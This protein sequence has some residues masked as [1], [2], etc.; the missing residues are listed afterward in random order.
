MFNSYNKL[1]DNIKENILTREEF[2]IELEIDLNKNKS[3]ILNYEKYINLLKY[4]NALF[5]K[6]KYIINRTTVL[7]VNYTQMVNNIKNSYRISLPNSEI[8]KYM[9]QI[10]N[11]SNNIIYEIL[12]K[13]LETNKSLKII[14]KT[15]HIKDDEINIKDIYDIDDLNTRIRVS[16]EKDID[17]KEINKL[18]ELFENNRK[19]DD[20]VEMNIIYRLKQRVSLI[21]LTTDNYD[22]SIDLTNVKFNKNMRNFNTYST[23]ELELEALIKNKINKKDLNNILNI[24]T[25]DSEKLIKIIQCSN[26]IIT[27]SD[28]LLVYKNYN[29]LLNHKDTPLT[30]DS[31][32]VISLEIQYLDLLVNKYTVTDKADGDHSFIFIT[33]NKVYIITQNMHIRFTGIEVDE[34]FN[35]T[36]LDGELIFV[37]KY[38]KHIFMGFD[39]LFY[40]GEDVRKKSLLKDRLKCIEMIVQKCF[41]LPKHK[42]KK[43]NNYPD[44]ISLDSNIKFY[45]NEL[46]NYFDIL[47]NDIQVPSNYPLIRPKYFIPL[48]G[49]HDSEIFIYSTI[50]WKYYINS[51]NYPYNLDG[52]VYQPIQHVYET[53]KKNIKMNDYKWKPEENNSI[54]FYIEFAKDDNNKIYTAYDNVLN[55][56]KEEDIGKGISDSTYDDNIIYKICYLYVGKK[57]DNK[58]TFVKFNPQYNNPNH[59]IH[60]TY[61]PID[62]K[63]NVKDIENNIIQDKTVVEFYYDTNITTL[64]KFRWKPI[65]TRHDKTE[66]V[67]KYSK[68]YGNN[69]QVSYKIWNSIKYPVLFNDIEILSDT[70]KYITHREKMMNLVNIDLFEKS[71]SDLYYD[72]DKLIDNNTKPQTDFHNAIKTI[73]INN[74][75]APV[76][77]KKK[78]VF[79]VGCGQ[80]GDIYKF[81]D[82]HVEYAIGLDPV[83]NNLHSA[84]G[85][86][87]RYDRM[88][89]TKPKTP[90]MEFINGDF[91][92]P[93]NTAQQLKTITDR[94]EKNIKLMDKYFNRKYN[95]LNIQF[96]FH[97]FLQN[98]ETWDNACN[99]INKLI[100]D[101][102]YV[103]ITC[104]D[105]KLVNK[106]LQENKGQYTQYITIKENKVLYHDIVQKY[107]ST[108]DVFKYGN[109]IDVHIARFMETGKYI[110][111]YMVDKKFIIPELKKKCNLSLIETDLFSNIYK[112]IDQYINKI[113]DVETKTDMK[114]FLNKLKAYYIKS[115]INNECLKITNLNRFYIFKKMKN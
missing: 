25:T 106:V 110:P 24:L 35:N 102:G 115:D 1:F 41:I 67:L 51:M 81:Y 6:N 16:S 14:K 55:K 58:E 79:D 66:S 68:K 37:S 47:I 80:G 57:I 38:N 98:K 7:D 54:D 70:N 100:A 104:F 22:I 84:T 99:N 30:I 4:F 60:I 73:L 96:A 94:T 91:N 90:L 93:L 31:K 77:N 39:C 45:K 20:K 18:I 15:Q 95:V 44:N 3:D 40:C 92:I 46:S 107:N 52:L 62:S 61:L 71:K 113:Y 21:L 97:Y 72:V 88:K 78:S 50:Y 108:N 23:Y 111:E 76:D 2:P 13:Q 86:M 75:I 26:Y 48:F 85:A 36:I 65:R 28:K 9:S 83:F 5:K 112:N 103:I 101:D 89:K 34:E 69:E 114:S 63:G 53:I 19:L 29:E 32:N 33:N 49:L 82:A 42:F 11:N 105:A 59:D 87:S 74:Y 17:H 64:N 10:G 43:I 12:L 27:E 56:M 109:T 8:S